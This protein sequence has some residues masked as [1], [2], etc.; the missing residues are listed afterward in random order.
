MVTDP[1]PARARTCAPRSSV[2]RAARAA[3]TLGDHKRTIAGLPLGTATS[4]VGKGSYFQVVR[5]A[6]DG[7]GADA[8]IVPVD[9]GLRASVSMP[10][11]STIRTRAFSGTS[12]N[13][14]VSPEGQL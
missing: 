5:G 7:A 10:R 9:R 6:D 11:P 13:T 4:G 8:G 3:V 14:W 2:S 1:T 12:E